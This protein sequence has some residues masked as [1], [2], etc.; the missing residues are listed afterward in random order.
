MK[1]TLLFALALVMVM[2]V[3]QS[4]A[5]AESK[6]GPIFKLGRG[7]TYLLA[8]PFQI[9]KEIIQTTGESDVVWIAPLKGMTEGLGSGIYNMLRQGMSGMFDILTFFTP[10]GRDWQPLFE[11]TSLIPEI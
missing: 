6:R 3:A 1:K 5:H 7:F 11:P 2:S 10:A 8:S 9:P 4:N